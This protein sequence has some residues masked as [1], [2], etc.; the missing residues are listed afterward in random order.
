MDVAHF[1]NVIVSLVKFLFEAR[2]EVYV[3]HQ[4]ARVFDPLAWCY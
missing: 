2:P 4:A 1:A 3:Y